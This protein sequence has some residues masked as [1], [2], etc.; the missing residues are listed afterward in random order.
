MRNGEQSIGKGIIV[1]S[2]LL[3]VLLLIPTV[4]YFP[5]WETKKVESP[6]VEQERLGV[7]RLFLKVPLSESSRVLQRVFT[8]CEIAETQGGLRVEGKDLLRHLEE[9]GI[10]SRTIWDELQREDPGL[11]FSDDMRQIHF[12]IGK[13]E[14][15]RRYALLPVAIVAVAIP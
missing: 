2:A 11:T 7:E 15:G 12:S 5:F 14:T 8:T 3:V 4:I 13:D 9:A 1:L 10:A 6:Y